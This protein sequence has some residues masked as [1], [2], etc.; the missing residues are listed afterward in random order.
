MS[1]PLRTPTKHPI[2]YSQRDASESD[3]EDEEPPINLHPAPPRRYS[4][5][6]APPSRQVP[7]YPTPDPVS[8]TA[9]P[10]YRLVPDDRIDHNAHPLQLGSLPP[11]PP[12]G[13][14]TLERNIQ[15]GLEKAHEREAERT[16]SR[17]Y[18][19]LRKILLQ[20]ESDRMELWVYALLAQTKTLALIG[21]FIDA[22][23]KDNK[24]VWNELEKQLKEHEAA[25]KS[26]IHQLARADF[27][28]T[29]ASHNIRALLAASVYR[30]DLLAE[31]F[32]LF[33]KVVKANGFKQ[34]M[35]DRMIREVV[36][37]HRIPVPPISKDRWFPQDDPTPDER[38]ESD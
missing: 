28:H 33:K 4:R 25:S 12:A 7:P 34:V 20:V 37:A 17:R 16:K 23:E 11:Q 18:E 22:Q 14:A 6:A 21:R 8:R 10:P 32:N 24:R 13:L 30:Q 1:L 38:D 35:D 3:D 36:K 15:V 2:R 5:Q 9:L 19:S 29:R 27:S 31:L 26:T